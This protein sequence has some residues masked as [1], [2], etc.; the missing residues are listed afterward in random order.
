MARRFAAAGARVTLFTARHPGSAPCTTSDG[1]RILRGG[2]TFG[3][4]SA[5]ARHLMRHRHAYDAVID[6]QNG[7]PYFSP[8]F[9]PRWTADICVIHHIHQP[10]ATSPSRSSACSASKVNASTSAPHRAARP[11]RDHR[12]TT[13]SPHRQAEQSALGPLSDTDKRCCF[14]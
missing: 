6:F 8:L 2:G 13:R 7:I 1:I 5:A 3:V 12:Q 9:T 10:Q 14:F 11:M 4:Y